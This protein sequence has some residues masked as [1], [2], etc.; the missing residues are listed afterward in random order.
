MIGYDHL[1]RLGRLGNQMFQYASLKGIARNRGYDWCIPHDFYKNF[2]NHKLF[3]CFKLESLKYIKR[4]NKEIINEKSFRFDQELFNSC[5]DE[6]SVC[7]FLQSEKYFKFIEEEVRQDFIFL[8]GIVEECE[9]A[10]EELRI[11]SCLLDFE[12]SISLHVRRADY[13]E[14]SD[15]HPPC[16]LEYY[17]KALEELP[18]DCPVIV[19]SDEL[20]WC[21]KQD[22]FKSGRFFFSSTGCHFVDLC[23]MTKCKYHIIANSSFSWWGA[24]LSNSDKVV[25]PKTWFG[26]Y[27]KNDDSD[28]VPEEWRRL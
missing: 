8:D 4:I 3:E 16:S 13:V 24:W 5:P 1:G 6:V 19:F 23:M 21:R 20:G 25:A 28:L 26:R 14:R 9:I 22:L 2:P 17:E 12:D 7:G 18:I 27:S 15:Y 10:F 11:K